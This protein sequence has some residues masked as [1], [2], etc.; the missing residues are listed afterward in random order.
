[1]DELEWKAVRSLEEMTAD[2]W[3]WQSNNPQGY[4]EA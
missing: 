3:R 1:M 2:T 4:P